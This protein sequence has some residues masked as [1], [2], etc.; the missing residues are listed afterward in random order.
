MNFKN[1]PKDGKMHKVPGYTGIKVRFLKQRKTLKEDWSY[2]IYYRIG[3]R[4]GKQILQKV[5][6]VLQ[7]MTAKKAYK[8][9]MQKIL[10]SEEQNLAIN[11][12]LTIE[13]IWELYAHQKK[14]L[15]SFS[16]IKNL[17]DYLSPFYKDTPF[18]ITTQKIKNFKLELKKQ[19][20][21]HGKT[22]SDQSI[23]HILKLLRTLLNFSVKN[24]ICK[25]NETLSFEIPNIENKVEEFLSS[26]QMKKYV[27]ELKKEQN[28][29]TKAF[30]MTAMFTG[31]RKNAIYHLSWQD[32][33]TKNNLIYLKAEYAKKK[34]AEYI[35]LPLPIKKILQSVPQKSS[36]LFLDKNNKPYDNYY[37]KAKSIKEKIGLP[38]NFRPLYMLRHNYASLLASHGVD[39]YTIQKLLTHNSPSMTQRYAHL[40]DKRLK[41]GSKAVSKIIQQ[42]F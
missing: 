28:I 37:E 13:K 30:I 41:N 19:K 33:D 15:R 27:N 23:V 24:G 34:K 1:I 14:D 3:G 38:K 40:S 22:L 42:Y 5:G 17:F 39:M 11:D 2:Y 18:S 4:R 26:S 21:K 10:E 29:Y 25:K 6:T 32:I 16:S 35:P 12:I 9:R 31:M 20:S 8:I 7:G 36:F